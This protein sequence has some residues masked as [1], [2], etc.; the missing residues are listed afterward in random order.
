MARTLVAY[1]T[2]TGNTKKVA[3]AIYDTLPGDKTIASMAE[4]DDNLE[5]YGLIVAG[6][7]V[8]YHSVPYGAELF[9]RKIPAGMKTALYCTHAS[10]TGSILSRQAVEYAAVL[11]SRTRLVGTFSCRGKVS[12][13]ALEA[14]SKEPIN[15]S[16]V[17][18]AASAA[19]HPDAHDLA[20][21]AAFAHWIHSF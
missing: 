18:M 17:E 11:V 5:A 21:A 3:E 12:M 6:F 2:L 4:A 16:W 15:E 7:P 9:L 10:F 14:M 13:Q 20:E 1:Y 19:T 8:Q